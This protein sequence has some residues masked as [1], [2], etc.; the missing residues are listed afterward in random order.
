ML[1]NDIQHSQTAGKFAIAPPTY[2]K[3]FPTI[4]KYEKAFKKQTYSSPSGGFNANRGNK[5]THVNFAEEN[6]Q[7]LTRELKKQK[8]MSKL[9][10]KCSKMFQ[11]TQSILAKTNH[12]S[13]HSVANELRS[14]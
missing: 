4:H 6:I 1:L 2:N 10:S 5:G 3:F 9:I 8:E 11:E 14:V 12:R 7:R 13:L